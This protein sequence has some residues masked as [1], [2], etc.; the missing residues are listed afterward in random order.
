MSSRRRQHLGFVQWLV[1]ALLS[2]GLLHAG[3]AFAQGFCGDGMFDPNAGE[4]CDDGNFDDCDGCSPTCDDES[5]LPDGDGDGFVDACDNCPEV[6]NTALDPNGRQKDIDKDGLGDICDDADILGSFVMGR[7]KAT[8]QF[9]PGG[10]GLGRIVIR[11]FLDAHPP[12]DS[13]QESLEEG[14]DPN[15][16]SGDEIVML[17]TI[18]DG[19][20]FFHELAFTRKECKL[21]IAGPI[22]RKVR[23]K[24]PDNSMRAVFRNV[25]F[26]PDVYK[27]AIRAKRQD[28]SP[29]TSDLISTVL[30]VGTIDRPDVI[31][32]LDPCVMRQGATKQLI[33]C[34]E[35]GS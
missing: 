2:L 4:E 16:N 3:P 19:V 13:F 8:S 22:L 30:K 27:F 34:A 29:F 6:W 14:L 24:V 12:L 10:D 1:V 7:F 21:I 9:K 20:S 11:G 35:P 18:D 26:A 33:K 17:I 32:E 5:L 31:G 23:C 25:P 28:N 15:S